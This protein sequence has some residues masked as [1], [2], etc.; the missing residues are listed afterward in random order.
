M[1]QLR[2]KM[3][4]DLELGNYSPLTVLEYA[5]C[6]RKFAA[7]YMRSPAE[8][9]EAEVRGFLLH[10]HKVRGVSLSRLKMY[11]AALKFFYARTLQRPEVSA[12][13]PWPKVR[14]KLPAVLEPEEVRRVLAK[15]EPPLY[16]TLFVTMY[17]TGVRI[18]EACKLRVED[19]D[20]RRGVIRIRG[21][22]GRERY[23]PLS[24]RLLPILRR[25]YQRERLRSPWLFPRTDGRGAVVPHQ[26]RRALAKALRTTSLGKR[27]TPHTL[28]HSF[29]TH[30]LEAGTDLR[31]IQALLG[32]ASIR[33]T[34][35]YTR[36]SKEFI[37]RSA[38]PLE[39][40]AND[41][42]KAQG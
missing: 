31:V 15:I 1:G 36:V 30:L 20:S 29:A 9:G 18:S 14:S 2:D 33:T 12:W 21:K 4:S 26:A 3:V 23:V 38:D 22:G 35:R 6:V 17:A 39:L 10:M 19:L 40:M 16:R 27:V 11:V 41:E 5:R 42:E 24:D 28:R 32:H 37:R 8:L 7:H 34:T 13:I 25:H